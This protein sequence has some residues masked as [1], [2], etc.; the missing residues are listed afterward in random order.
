[1]W[2]RKKIEHEVHPLALQKTRQVSFSGFVQVKEFAEEQHPSS[3]FKI[4]QKLDQR[5]E[6]MFLCQQD[7]LAP[8][9]ILHVGSSDTSSTSTLF[10]DSD[11]SWSSESVMDP[12]SRLCTPMSDERHNESELSVDEMRHDDECMSDESASETEDDDDSEVDVYV[13]E[14]EDEEEVCVNPL[15]AALTEKMCTLKEEEEVAQMRFSKPES[16][17]MKWTFKRKK[18]VQR[19][20]VPQHSRKILLLGDMNTGKSNLINCG[21]GL[22]WVWLIGRSRM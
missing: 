5:N 17:K 22:R 15:N 7:A 1:M 11:E 21:H 20:K 10:T 12:E 14:T 3:F 16:V 18:K 19:L 9:S 6:S 13:D 8:H 4:Q 2:G